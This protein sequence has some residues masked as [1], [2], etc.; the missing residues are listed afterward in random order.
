MDIDA[1]AV[2]AFQ[3]WLRA[4][5]GKKHILVSTVTLW[6]SYNRLRFSFSK[7]EEPAC[8]F[9]F[10]LNKHQ[11]KKRPSDG[12]ERGNSQP[13]QAKKPREYADAFS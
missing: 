2:D 1:F 7:Q 10:D 3:R 11:G 8:Q 12:K 5:S 6:C 9:F 4:S 13:K